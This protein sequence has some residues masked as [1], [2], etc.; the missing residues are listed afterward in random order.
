MH[1][2]HM[3]LLCRLQL[4]DRHA[5]KSNRFMSIDHDYRA[6]CGVMR[7]TQRAMGGSW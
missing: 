5:Y 4:R 1:P 7:L 6:C 2:V 3:R